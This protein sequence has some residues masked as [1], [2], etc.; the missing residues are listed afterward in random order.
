MGATVGVGAGEGGKERVVDVDDPA[1]V[2]I[3]E[4]RAEYLHVAGEH[5]DVHAV[6]EQD[7][8]N[9]PLLLRLRL[10]RDRK[11]VKWDAVDLGAGG[12]VGVV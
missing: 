11:V 12:E 5:H 4:L 8:Q 9:L 6:L 3:H 7:V 10:L 1:R 2:N